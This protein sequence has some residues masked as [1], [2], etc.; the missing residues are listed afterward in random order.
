MRLVRGIG[1]ALLWIVA[2]LLGLVAVVLCITVILLPLGLPLL[3]VAR[4]LF[5]IATRLMMPRAATHPVAE[6]DKSLHKKARAVKKNA[7][8]TSLGDV[9]RDA[10]KNLRKQQRRARKRLRR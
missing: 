1:G 9:T 4:R 2:S 5:G 7:P 8:S 6:L 10:Q 3:L